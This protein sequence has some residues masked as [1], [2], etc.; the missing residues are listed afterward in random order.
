VGKEP[1]AVLLG[2][3]V[4][5]AG[6]P[7]LKQMMAVY[8]ARGGSVLGVQEVRPDEVGRYGILKPRYLSPDI[9]QV[10]DLIEKPTPK[11]APSNLAILG[12]Y[13]LE[14]Q[15]FSIIAKQKPPTI[16]AMTLNKE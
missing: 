2:D 13:L 8:E 4:I 1:F 12:R 14:P 9:Y 11:K 5:D 10:E 15:I 3:D 7:C 6:T 16:N